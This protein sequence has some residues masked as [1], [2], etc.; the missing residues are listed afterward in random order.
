VLG[1]FFYEPLNEVHLLQSQLH[2]VEMLRL[3]RHVSC[4][5]L[6]ERERKRKRE[7]EKKKKRKKKEQSC[8]IANDGVKENRTK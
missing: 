1:V 8:I 2:R 5:E 7:R 6:R 4:P 3:A